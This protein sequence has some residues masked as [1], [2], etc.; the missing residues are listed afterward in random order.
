MCD[1]NSGIEESH[2]G[3]YEEEEGLILRFGFYNLMGKAKFKGNFRSIRSS[4]ATNHSWD[5]R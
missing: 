3:N 4:P 5:K 1:A 2:T